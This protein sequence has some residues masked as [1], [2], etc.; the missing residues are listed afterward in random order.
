MPCWT[1]C[2]PLSPAPPAST[3]R[4][5]PRRALSC[6]SSPPSRAA[7]HHPLVPLLTTRSTLSTLSSCFC[8]HCAHAHL[9]LQT[10]REKSALAPLFSDLSA[11]SDVCGNRFAQFPRLW[12]PQ[13]PRAAT[14]GSIRCLVSSNNDVSRF[15]FHKRKGRGIGWWWGQGF[16]ARRGCDLGQELRLFS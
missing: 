13:W 7:P 12:K 1:S 6:R 8:R 4:L 2:R 5:S 14:S 16:R 3:H 10:L 15:G 11:Q 9:F